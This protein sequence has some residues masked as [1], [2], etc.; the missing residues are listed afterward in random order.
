MACPRCG[1]SERQPIAPGYFRCVSPVEMESVVWLPAGPAQQMVP[2]AQR[3]I[4][5]CGHRYQD[6]SAGQP[7]PLCACGLLSIGTCTRCGAWFCGDCMMGTRSA[8]LCRTCGTAEA[9]EAER[10]AAQAEFEAQSIELARQ[11]ALTAEFNEAL[12]ALVALIGAG[13][14]AP[15]TYLHLVGFPD[16]A[17][18][19]LY[20]RRAKRSISDLTCSEGH[21]G[22]HFN[23]SAFP[24]AG[25]IHL[26]KFEAPAWEVWRSTERGTSWVQK[27]YA[28]ADGSLAY[29]VYGEGGSPREHIEHLQLPEGLRGDNYTVLKP[30]VSE[31]MPYLFG[32]STGD[33]FGRPSNPFSGPKFYNA[34]YAGLTRSLIDAVNATKS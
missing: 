24:T 14:P 21:P 20:G 31:L 15:H 22:C 30:H 32:L 16:S 29:G 33:A 27:L 8:R 26:A 13:A 19:Q 28:L 23:G 25:R 1:G 6:G 5:Q 34:D 7:T 12:T 3:S 11:K 9:R 2:V 18:K 10:A 17:S 4:E